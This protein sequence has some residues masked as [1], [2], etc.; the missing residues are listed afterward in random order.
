MMVPGLRMA[1]ILRS[2][3]ALDLQ[4]FDHRFDDPVDLG[5][6]LQ[7]ILKIPDGHQAGQRGLEER[8]RLR[9]HRRFQSSGRDAVA[10]RTIGVR[11]NDI[12]QVR[13]NTS[14]GQVRGDASAHGARA[15]YGDFLNA[16]LHDV[17]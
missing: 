14:I 5:Q 6:L 4:V 7:I 3:V 2:R 17:V 12:E 1:S 13:G 15:Q 8:R 16:F 9:L 11:G 10:R